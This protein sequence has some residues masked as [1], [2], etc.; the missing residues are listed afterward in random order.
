MGRLPCF[1]LF[2]R[3]F[4]VWAL[5]SSS[6]P[7]PQFREPRQSHLDAS[8]SA[9]LRP[10]TRS[11]NCKGIHP[12]RV[13]AMNGCG[14]KPALYL[15]DGD[16]IIKFGL[17]GFCFRSDCFR[18]DF[19]LCSNQPHSRP[20]PC[21]VSNFAGCSHQ[22][23]ASRPVCLLVSILDVPNGLPKLVHLQIPDIRSTIKPILALRGSEPT[24]L[25]GM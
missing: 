25:P 17:G 15:K 22:K 12:G 2:E 9:E 20:A 16:S 23:S 13:L 7:H 8:I 11:S 19:H 5:P 3:G 1:S 6:P 21:A 18:V 24:L 4:E 14:S 10:D